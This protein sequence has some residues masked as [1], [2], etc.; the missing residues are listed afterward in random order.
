MNHRRHRSGRMAGSSILLILLAIFGLAWGGIFGPYFWDEQ[1]VREAGSAALREWRTTESLEKGKAKLAS[2][3]SKEGIEYIDPVADCKFT[4]DSGYR[5]LE[6]GWNPSVY[7]P[8]TQYYKTLSFYLSIAC[9][10]EGSISD[11]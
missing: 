6:C 7:Y 9:D 3:L 10:S 2:R 8:G 4:M 11:A 5:Y 1:V